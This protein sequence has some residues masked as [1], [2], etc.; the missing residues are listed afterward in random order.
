LDA[1]AHPE[2]YRTLVVRVA[3][4]SAMWVDLDSVIQDEIIARTEQIL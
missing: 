1:R 3:G 2:Q 4:Y